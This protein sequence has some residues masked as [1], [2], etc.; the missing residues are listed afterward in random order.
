MKLTTG[1]N[2]GLAIVSL[3]MVTHLASAA[4]WE[5][6]RGNAAR[7][8][9]TAETLPEGL[10]SQWTFKPRHQPD[11]AWPRSERMTFDQAFH[12]VVKDGTVYFGSSVDGAVYAVDAAS[13]EVRW[14]FIT[15]GPIRFAP[16]LWQDRVF[17]ASDDGYLYALSAEDGSL[18]WKK[19][20]GP[21]HARRLGNSRMI[22][23]WPARGGPMV[24]DDIVYFAAGIWPTDGIYFYA[25]NCETGDVLWQNDDSGSIYMPQP[26]GGADAE[27]GVSAQ[28]YLV[29][30]DYQP[31]EGELQKRILMPTGRAVP[32]AFERETGKF[33]YF[34]LQQF[35]HKGGAPTMAVGGL[36]LNSGIAFDVQTGQADSTIGDGAMAATSDGLVRVAGDQLQGY[37]W[38]EV[39]KVDRRGNASKAQGLEPLWALKGVDG[40]GEIIVAGNHV[41]AGGKDRVAVVDGPAG[42]VVWSHKVEGTVQGLAVADGRLLVS[43][44][45]GTIHCFATTEPESDDPA[46]LV[47]D[48]ASEKTQSEIPTE[49]AAAAAEI[50]ES[51]ETTEGYCLDFDCGEGYLAEALAHSTDWHIIAVD[52]DFERSQRTRKRLADAG[53]LGNRITLVWVEDL[54]DSRLPTY[55]ANLIVSGR[56]VT[57]GESLIASDGEAGRLLRPYGGTMIVGKPSNMRREQRGALA[58]AGSWTHQY[59]DPGNSLCSTDDLIKGPLGML[60]FRDID[61][62]MP[63]RHGRGPGPLFYEGFLYSEGLD[64]L[65]CVDAYNGRVVWKYSLPGILKAYDGDELMGTAGTHSNYCVSDDGV[66][67][68][69]DG[70][71]LRLD[72]KT[73]ELLGKFEVPVDAQGKPGGTWGYIACVDGVLYGTLADPEHVVTYRYLNRGGDMKSLL[74]ESK[75]FFALDARNGESLW[76]Y[77]AQHSIRHNAIAIGPERVYLV[78]RPQALFDRE[79][80][81]KPDEHAPGVLLAF[82]AKKGY[83]QWKNEVNIDG[84]LLSLAGD[85]NTLLMGYQPTRFALASEIGGKLSTFDAETGE[86]RWEKKTKYESRPM[87][88][89]NT[90]YA[91]GGAWDLKTGEEREFNFSRSY[92]CGVL[93]GSKHTMLFR[94]ATL[95]YFD[96]G[97]N[98]KTENYGGVRPGCWINAIPAG[99]IVLVPDASAGCKCSYLNQS[100][101]ALE[102]DGLRAPK[103]EPAGGAFADAVTVKLQAD[104]LLHEVRY[105]LDGS[106]PTRDSLRYSEPLEIG[107]DTVLKARAFD[108]E[109]KPSRSVDAQFTFDPHLL[110]VEEDR[111]KVWD[112]KDNPIAGPSQWI[113]RGTEIHQRSNIYQ[114]SATDPDPEVERYGTLRIF[115]GGKFA[116]GQ[117]EFEFNSEDDDTLGLA[118][119]LQDET[120]HYLWAADMQRKYRILARKN[121]EDYKVLAQNGL[122]YRRNHWHHVKIE[123]VG[124]KLIV[125]V[126]GEKDFEVEDE[127]FAEGTLALHSWGTQ[128]VRFR[129]VRVAPG[130]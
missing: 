24:V 16:T 54:D 1:P 50:V 118:F 31:Q 122:G 33:Q 114:G 64:E 67:V 45:N 95:G 20:G 77:D 39:E 9:Y 14:S 86:L 80:D 128:G 98:E 68:R 35:G 22:S 71:C 55:F 91:Q 5:T 61:V 43:T 109:G 44:D 52:D 104:E 47:Y 66:F 13:G 27:S 92:G 121:R 78:D 94:S 38:V 59:S 73:G 83:Q 26:H 4:E 96:L 75:T 93:A 105:T 100:W 34:H 117:I 81:K 70:H 62:A 40:S 130:S 99:G 126:D 19:R 29:A 37:R 119:R 101:F 18:H 113:V 57:E 42:K 65:A 84:T 89:E 102:P 53:L 82:E 8:G 48:Q 12:T 60:W 90:I 106:A 115:E 10:R 120:H 32:A 127:T 41:I 69:R 15:E 108:L 76:R 107:S 46:A 56:S 23:K 7:D 125:W 25:L 58:G 87:I 97:V 124:P 123:M 11:R 72:R 110:P 85:H 74:T 116:D 129:G 63:Q 6:Y 28:G 17:V 30:S 3:L 51:L 36:F 112:T 2:L 21:D 49:I 79:R 88:N 111:W 103:I